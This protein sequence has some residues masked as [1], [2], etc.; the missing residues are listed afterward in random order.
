[1]LQTLSLNI[2]TTKRNSLDSL[3]ISVDRLYLMNCS[4]AGLRIGFLHTFRSSNVAP[5]L[6]NH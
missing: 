5:K 4:V 3:L 1:M 2:L 6:V